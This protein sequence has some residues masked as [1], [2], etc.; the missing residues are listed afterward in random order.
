MRHENVADAAPNTLWTVGR[1]I[2]WAREL[3][4]NKRPHAVEGE[5]VDNWIG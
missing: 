4:G 3:V 5:L 1:G 2:A